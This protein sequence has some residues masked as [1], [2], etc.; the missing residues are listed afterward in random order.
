MLAIS[1]YHDGLHN[2]THVP[3]IVHKTIHARE[4]RRSP[5]LHGQPVSGPLSHQP[6]EADQRQVADSMT[7]WMRIGKSIGIR[8]PQNR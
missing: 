5:L 4:H 1:Q 8:M 7:A 3:I 2:Q 6:T